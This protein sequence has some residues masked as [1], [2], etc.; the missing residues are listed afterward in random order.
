M[1]PPGRN[2]RMKEA[3]I[4]TCRHMASTLLPVVVSKLQDT[5][6]IVSTLALQVC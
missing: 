6:Y 3:N 4:T 1:Q 5:P 2:M